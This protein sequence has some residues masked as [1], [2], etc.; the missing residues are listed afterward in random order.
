M[1]VL[2]LADQVQQLQQ[3]QQQQLLGDHNAAPGNTQ[4]GMSA[5]A[6]ATNGAAAALA[7]LWQMR[8]GLHV[9]G[10]CHTLWPCWFLN[11]TG[12]YVGTAQRSC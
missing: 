5:P 6:A 3:Q 4:R 7:M 11:A 2:Q 1:G 9:Q 8:H 12:L 10:T